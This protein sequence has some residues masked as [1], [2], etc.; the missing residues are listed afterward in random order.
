MIERVR[1]DR[2]AHSAKASGAWRHC[3]KLKKRVRPSSQCDLYEPA[4]Q[5]LEPTP[6]SVSNGTPSERHTINV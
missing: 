2:C 3:H 4:C 5:P 1:C 6:P